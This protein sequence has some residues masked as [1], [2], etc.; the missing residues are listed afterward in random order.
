MAF[1]DGNPPE[2][3]FTHEGEV[4]LN[5]R[6]QKIELNDDGS[7]KN[8]LPNNGPVIRGDAYIFASPEEWI[9]HGDSEIIDATMKELAKLF[10]DE[11]AADQSKAKILSD[12]SISLSVYKIVPGTEPY[13]PLQL[14]PVQ[15]NE[16]L[17]CR[18]E[19]RVPRQ[20]LPDK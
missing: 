11:I 19:K 2:R 5:S 7:V 12:L 8:F 1:L 20:A 4:H 15:D 16:L 18:F 17:L 13:R 6:I 3:L 14:S 10:P 9:S